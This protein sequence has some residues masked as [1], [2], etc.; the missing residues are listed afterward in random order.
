MRRLRRMDYRRIKVEAVLL[1]G[2]HVLMVRPEN[3]VWTL[4]SGEAEE[5]EL[6]EDAAIRIMA[7]TAG[8]EVRVSR[9]L[10]RDKHVRDHYRLVLTFLVEAQSPRFEPPQG[11]SGLEVD[12]RN[13]RSPELKE[14]I[15]EK[16]L[17]GKE[18][19]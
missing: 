13:L 18:R 6:P 7:E 11:E 10:N 2:H 15:Y 5:G 14:K 1:N 8:V 12:W 19:V 4:P 17:A 9:T 3:G 16:Y